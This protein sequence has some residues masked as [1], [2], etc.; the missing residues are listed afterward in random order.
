MLEI[1]RTRLS[2]CRARKQERSAALLAIKAEERQKQVTHASSIKELKAELKA[3][4]WYTHEVEMPS[5]TRGAANYGVCLGLWAAV[6]AAVAQAGSP[7]MGWVAAAALTSVPCGTA[8]VIAQMEWPRL[9][10]VLVARFGQL[11]Y[12]LLRFAVAA[13]ARLA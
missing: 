5:L 6:V 12:Q 11:L 8:G 9:L 13:A 7:P 2:G 4:G 10:A 3:L 1:R